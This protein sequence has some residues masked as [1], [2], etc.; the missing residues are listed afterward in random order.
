MVPQVNKI[1]HMKKL[2]ASLA[3]M[4]VAG[5][6]QIATAQMPLQSDAKAVGTIDS[7]STADGESASTDASTTNESE[8]C[9]SEGAY[10]LAPPVW[11]YNRC[12]GFP[13]GSCQVIYPQ[14]KPL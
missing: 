9:S 6:A 1:P 11:C 10:N 12:Q 14:C 5:S 4:L 8:Q 7:S 13:P 2:L 3:L